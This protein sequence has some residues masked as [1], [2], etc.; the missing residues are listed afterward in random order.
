MP[1]EK[2]PGSL[3]LGDEVDAGSRVLGMA[4]LPL[5]V[6]LI[7]LAALRFRD[8]I[9]EH[10]FQQQFQRLEGTVKDAL[11]NPTVGYLIEVSIYT[12]EFGVP[13][14]PGGQLLYTV[15]VGVEPIDALAE[16]IRRPSIRAST[17]ATSG[18]NNSSFFIWLTKSE[19]KLVGRTIPGVFRKAFWAA[20]TQE[21][22]RRDL[23]AAWTRSLPQDS[24][25]SI[26]RAEYWIDVERTRSRLIQDAR[27]KQQ[28]TELVDE[29]R[30]LQ[31]RA[32]GLYRRFQDLQAELFRQQYFTNT[33]AT[34]SGITDIVRGAIELGALTS[35]SD[36][37]PATGAD[38]A[39][40]ASIPDALTI[41]QQEIRSTSDTYQE[42]KR[43]LTIPLNKL[44]VLDRS[45]GDIFDDAG[46]PLPERQPFTPP[47][48]P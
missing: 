46:V 44:Q 47:V 30:R 3:R 9:I 24:Y 23:A 7:Q 42:V 1:D 28:V 39:P 43:S 34:V 45:L 15:G 48:I 33:L 35:R 26:Q 11:A 19:D 36:N 10:N 13:V 18:L 40:S 25:A 5:E 38:L 8:A 27:R 29:M 2:L 21:A 4:N 17:D 37:T 22:K 12:N 6:E 20:A 41:T 31:E 16:S 32:N 14:V